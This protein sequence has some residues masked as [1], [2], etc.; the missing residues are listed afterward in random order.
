M[1]FKEYKA[2]LLN[3]PEIKEEYDR[4]EPEYELIKSII[5]E[6]LRQDMTQEQLAEKIG[7]Q[8]TSIVR[9]E[10]PNYVKSLPMI[11]KIAQALDCRLVIRLEP[12]SS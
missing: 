4:L 10:N 8:K 6:R 9:L 7:A 1:N 3:D 11:K 12:K 2:Q 5:R